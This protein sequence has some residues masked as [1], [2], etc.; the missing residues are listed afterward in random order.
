MKQVKIGAGHGRRFH[1]DLPAPGFINPSPETI[2]ASM[3]KQEQMKKDMRALLNLNI[4]SLDPRRQSAESKTHDDRTLESGL[5]AIG[6]ELQRGEQELAENWHNFTGT[7]STVRITYPKVYRIKTDAER[8][9]EA[10]ELH[11]LATKI[12]SDGFK[13]RMSK[14][15]VQVLLDGDLDETQLKEIY[16]E[17]DNADYIITDPNIIMSSKQDG[18]G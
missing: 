7:P 4:A 13:R 9:S 2:E 5:S 14:K 11:K 10:E 1:K 18:F 8:L 6:L 3:A 16:T 12:P 17:I 15:I